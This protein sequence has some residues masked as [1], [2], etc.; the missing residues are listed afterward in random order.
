MTRLL[1]HTI[2]II[3]LF[4]LCAPA[5][6][7]GPLTVQREYENELQQARRE[8]DSAVALLNRQG[9]KPFKYRV[10]LK[11]NLSY[12]PY[13]GY[14]DIVGISLDTKLTINFNAIVS[15]YVGGTFG[16]ASNAAYVFAGVGV[17]KTFMYGNGFS[18]TP[19]LGV[20]TGEYGYSVVYRLIGVHAIADFGFSGRRFSP[21]LTA[22]TRYSYVFHRGSLVSFPLLG[23]GLS[24]KI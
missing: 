23:A 9:I 5:P 3:I 17:E 7:A 22:G 8:R 10:I 16:I 18:I 1:T 13:V 14:E 21:Y 15:P 12:E 24:L 2:Y 6:H 19:S 11:A 20:H 4:S